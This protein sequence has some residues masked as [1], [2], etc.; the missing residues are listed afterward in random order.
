MANDTHYDTHYDPHPAPMAQT[1]ATPPL[2]SLK[3]SRL[4][5]LEEV[6]GHR[7]VGRTIE[8]LSD[9]LEITR[10]AVQQHLTALERDGLVIV[11]GL[12]STGGRPSRTYAL[13][14]A[15]LEL[16]PRSYALLAESLLRHGREMFGDEGVNA[17]LDSMASEVAADV[18]PR[19]A[20]K[21]GPDR[22]AEVVTILNEFGYGASVDEDGAIVAVNCVFRNVARSSRSAC[23]FDLTLLGAMLDGEVTH[24]ACMADGASCCRFESE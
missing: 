23:R 7:D 12:R 10:T 17:L 8:E 2:A 1:A 19:L 15:G 18:E 14:D 11:Q 13:T 16:F 22:R 21:T 20:G 3:G 5:L 4:R 24:G 6:L 9:A